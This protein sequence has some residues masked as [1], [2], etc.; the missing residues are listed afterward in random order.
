MPFLPKLIFVPI[1]IPKQLAFQ[2]IYRSL[3]I[4][5]GQNVHFET[6]QAIWQ[7]LPKFRTELL[8]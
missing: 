4:Q 3:N 7:T 5:N 1:S 8:D 2:D 6:A